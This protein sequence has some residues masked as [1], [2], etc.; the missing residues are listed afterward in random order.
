MKSNQFA[1]CQLRVVRDPQGSSYLLHRKV[2]VQHV[3][4][5]DDPYAVYIM[6]S[7]SAGE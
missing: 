2:L 7:L 6:H 3:V 5:E 4:T 1:Y